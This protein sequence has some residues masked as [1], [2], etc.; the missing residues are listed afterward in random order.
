LF[1]F[2]TLNQIY[3]FD[4]L[5][6]IWQV[7]FILE[8]IKFKFSIEIE[9]ELQ[10]FLCPFNNFLFVVTAATLG[11][12]RIYRIRFRMTI[13]KGPFQPS[14]VQIGQVVKV[15]EQ[16]ITVV[17]YAVQLFKCGGVGVVLVSPDNAPIL[18]THGSTH[19]TILARLGKGYKLYLCR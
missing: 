14:L 16:K 15:S 11:G 13:T 2:F 5:Q 7:Y 9:I 8:K 12:I 19:T 10:G 18:S 3:T 6:I 4:F 17:S 1:F